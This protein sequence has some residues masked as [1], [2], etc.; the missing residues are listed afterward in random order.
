MLWLK[1]MSLVVLG[2]MTATRNALAGAS[3]AGAAVAGA[4]VA[5]AAA[6][7]GSA[8]GVAGAAQ[9]LNTMDRDIVSITSH[10]AFF[11]SILLLV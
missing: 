6:V 5:G 8:V 2:M 7:G 11:I 3:V 4:S 10:A 9:A 1:A